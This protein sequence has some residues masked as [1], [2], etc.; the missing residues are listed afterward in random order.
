MGDPKTEQFLSKWKTQRQRKYS[1]GGRPKDRDKPSP[2]G[3][4]KD[5]ASLVQVEDQ[6]QR[7]SSPSGRPIDKG[8]LVQVE[9]PKTEEV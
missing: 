8:S 2:G 3:R 4:P 7:Q 9:D 5:R 1:P 6:R